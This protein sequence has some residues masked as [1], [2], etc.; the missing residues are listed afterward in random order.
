MPESPLAAALFLALLA[1][2]LASPVAAQSRDEGPHKTFSWAME[3]D[4]LGTV[5]VPST[6]SGGWVYGPHGIYYRSVPSY[7]GDP[8]FEVIFRSPLSGHPTRPERILLQVPK[9]F[10]QNPWSERA[11]VIGFH[12]FGVSEKD[13]FLNTPLPWHCSSRGW[14][15]VAP[16]G[17]TDT[18]FAS[19]QSQ[20]SLQAISHILFSLIPFNY[21][22]VYGVGFSMGG[23]C[24]L[25]YAMRHLDP[26]QLQFAGVVVHTA[27]MDMIEVCQSDP[28]FSDTIL[29]NWLHYGV[30]WQDEP[31][32]YERVSPVRFS[33][34]GLVDADRAPVVNFLHRPIF[35]HYN[36]ADPNPKLVHAMTEL[37]SFLTLRGANVCESIIYDPPAGHSWTTLPLG[38]ALD[39]VGQYS[40]R[41][42][43]PQSAEMFVDRPGKWLH[44]EIDSL[45]PATF[46][47][48]EF[49]LAPAGLPTSNAFALRATRDVDQLKIRTVRL[50]LDASSP[51]SFLHESVDGTADTLI[52]CGYTF[53]PTSI[54]VDG[55]PPDHQSHDPATESLTI[56][57]TPDGHDARIDITP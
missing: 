22:R 49:E 31:F 38:Q 39:F 9:T 21:N 37:R 12:S 6:S 15:L 47:R 26:R 29:A 57:P 13:I 5:E 8:T 10:Y 2:C 54:L 7:T 36:L 44:A 3:V 27:P 48:Y 1:P 25:S 51:L 16:L 45:S 41:S 43:F 28:W 18:S 4:D 33:P 32:E 55:A 23:L 56:R 30:N 11:L 35:L 14:L 52:L 50:G 19:G 34:S 20:S 46:G 53:P 42:T 40:I 17:L 24:A